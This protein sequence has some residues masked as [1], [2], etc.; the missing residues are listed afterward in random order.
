MAITLT[1]VEFRTLTPLMPDA[2]TLSDTPK[3]SQLQGMNPRAV[4]IPR[5]GK[6]KRLHHDDTE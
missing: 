5:K 3:I 2:N 6:E 4:T 1:P